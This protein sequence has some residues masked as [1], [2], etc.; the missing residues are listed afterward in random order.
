MLDATA[1]TQNA[2]T[3]EHGGR[4]MWLSR[5]GLIDEPV[6]LV[7]VVLCHPVVV[8]GSGNLQQCLGLIGGPM[9]LLTQKEWN[10]PVGSA[11]TLQE[12]TFVAA[13]GRE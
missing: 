2:T 10:R 8:A 6:K 12:R 9:Q 5:C 13:D 7:E 11:V 3:N 1:F 4:A